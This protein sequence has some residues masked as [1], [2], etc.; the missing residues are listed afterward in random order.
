M[1]CIVSGGIV[2]RYEAK[3][4]TLIELMVVVAIV[5]ILASMAIPR[6]QDYALGAQVKRVHAELSAYKSVVEDK[7]SEGV[8]SISSSDIGYVQSNLI[9]S[10]PES[11]IDILSDGSVVL[12]ATM[13]GNAGSGLFGVRISVTR[14]QNGGWKCEVDGSK[15]SGWKD[16]Y[17]PSAC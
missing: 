15:A 7:V 11:I 2:N 17:R 4:Y 8:G 10:D 6:Y 1:D 13:G 3:A 14:D 9:S 16:A 12:A 5:G